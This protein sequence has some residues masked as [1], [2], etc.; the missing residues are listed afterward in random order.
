MNNEQENVRA[1]GFSPADLLSKAP[2]SNPFPFLAQLRSS[3]TL[4]ATPESSGPDTSTVWAV[5]RLEEVVQFLKN[6]LFVVNPST[7]SGNKKQLPTLRDA[8]GPLEG[9]FVQSMLAVDGLDHQRLRSLA[10]KAFT[11][12]YVQSL[13]PSIQQ[14]ADELL[15]S[16]QNHGHM[17]LVQ[18]Y[19]FP[20]PIQVISTMLGGG[21]R[22]NLES[23]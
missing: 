10:S 19:A 16:V 23:D 7:L 1:G 21:V 22:D 13:H 17:D 9:P 5:T 11:P 14:I 12:R 15:D 3:G 8:Q 4:V 18:D 6:P 20:L 2:I